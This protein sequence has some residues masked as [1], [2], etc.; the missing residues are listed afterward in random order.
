MLKHVV[1]LAVIA[2]VVLVGLEP[3]MLAGD[4]K[5]TAVRVVDKEGFDAEI[6][7]HQGKIVLVDCWATWCVPC[8]KEFPKTVAMS[9]DYANK[10]LVVI[11]LSFDE[12]AD[13]KAPPKVQ[14]FLDKQGAD[15]PNL[16]SELPLAEEGGAAFGINDGALPHMMLFDRKGKLIKRL[17]GTEEKPLGHADIASAV[18]NALKTSK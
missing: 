9:H 6:A 1:G 10:G 16:I 12:L 14:K 17:A 3:V 13:G 11:S 7:K 8:V 4:S 18:E 5:A 2:S 15:F